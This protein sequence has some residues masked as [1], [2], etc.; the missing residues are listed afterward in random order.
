MDTILMTARD[1]ALD[2]VRELSRDFLKGL[3]SRPVGSQARFEDLVASLGGALPDRGVDPVA[4]VER[5]AKGVEPGLVAS[6][7]PRY[8]GFVIGGNLP[9]ALGAD[10]LTSTWDQNAGLAAT[11]PAAAAAEV[12]VA[13]WIK[14]LLGVPADAAVGL[15]TGCQMANFAGLAAARHVVLARAGWDVE[16]NGLQGAPTVHVLI[17]EEAH[18][19]IVSALKMLGLGTGRAIRVAADD[20]GRMKL[21]ALRDALSRV[22]G[23]T[24]VCAQA[25]NVNTG[26]FDPLPEIAQIVHERGGWL[27]IDGAFGLW[28]AATPSKRALIRGYEAADSWATDAHKWLNV[29][30][31]SGIAIVKD[32]AAMAAAFN[33]SGAYLIRTDGARDGNDYTP[34]A[35]RR[36]R[37]FALW[38]GLLSLGKSGVAE[39]V[40]R[41]CSHAVRLAEA[42]RKGG[43]TVLNDVVLNQVLVRFPPKSGGDADAFTRAVTARLQASGVCWASGTRW[44]GQEALRL[45]VS[46]W[47]TTAED[48]DRSAAAILAAFGEE[49]GR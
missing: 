11:S 28:A 4:V 44:H 3:D 6:A 1:A 35:S 46:N 23:P 13:D 9:A 34:D 14:T 12:V 7:G 24:I 38:A 18:A 29:P 39:L 41:C 5:L 36:A 32:S 43:V 10:W 15:V 8:F 37:G 19:T 40:E 31:D 16:A 33:K 25:G 17:G 22:T 48:I 21:D 27:H 30:Y 42:L 26:A 2:R 49:R 20:Q 47:S 45:S